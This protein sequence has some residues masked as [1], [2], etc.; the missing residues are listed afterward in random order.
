MKFRTWNRPPP[1]C[2]HPRMRWVTSQQPDT[3]LHSVSCQ[4]CGKV[5]AT[6]SYAE[7]LR[8]N[9]NGLLED[10]LAAGLRPPGRV[11]PRKAVKRM[12]LA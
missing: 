5:L 1:P 11:R 2:E 12:V 7:L 3:D 8:S 4:D 9:H 10:R 6:L